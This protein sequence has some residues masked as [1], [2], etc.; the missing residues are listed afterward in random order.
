[1]LSMG[2]PT[3]SLTGSSRSGAFF[4]TARDAVRRAEAAATGLYLSICGARRPGPLVR[5]TKMASRGIMPVNR[6]VATTGGCRGEGA[7]RR[8][9]LLSLAGALAMSGTAGGRFASAQDKKVLKAS[10]VHPEGY[11]T[12]QA[13]ENM[14]KK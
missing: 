14:G 13:V 6:S 10:D 12:V 11:P 7:M 5:K 8:R 2:N 4:L 1:R 3:S 9:D